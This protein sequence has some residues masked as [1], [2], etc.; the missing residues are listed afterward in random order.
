MGPTVNVINKK[1][2]NPIKYKKNLNNL[3]KSR[4]S[5]G[6]KAEKQMFE[7]KTV[8]ENNL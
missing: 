7:A 3:V 5:N 2:K 4:S 8:I 1:K 6:N